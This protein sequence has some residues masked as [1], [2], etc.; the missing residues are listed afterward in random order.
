[1]DRT[2]NS[3]NNLKPA[4]K[5]TMKNEENGIIPFLDIQV[6]KTSNGFATSVYSK[7]IHIRYYLNFQSNHSLSTKE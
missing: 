3:G 1:M 2:D 7:Q 6:K 5:F 4:I